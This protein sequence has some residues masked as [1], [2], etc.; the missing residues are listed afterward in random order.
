[1]KWATKVV[2]LVAIMNVLLGCSVNILTFGVEDTEREY[3]IGHKS[4]PKTP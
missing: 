1:M 3:T 4:E 2:L